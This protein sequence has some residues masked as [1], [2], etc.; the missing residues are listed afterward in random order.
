MKGLIATLTLL[1]TSIAQA[2]AYRWV[3][4]NG[5]THFGD[6]PPANAVTKEVRLEKAQPSIDATARER[7]QR[8]D[9]FLRQSEKERA[10]RKEAEAQQEAKAE[11]LRVHCERMEARLKHLNTVSGI[12]QLNKDGERV[13]VND[14][15][16]ERIR[17]EFRARV[18]RECNI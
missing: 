4:E 16:N 12:Y 14:E 13:F 15:E 8:V 1:A 10:A 11:K 6:R 9:E 17:E 2:G 3:D 5:Q 18:H 7:K